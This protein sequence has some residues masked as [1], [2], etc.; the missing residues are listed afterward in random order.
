MGFSILLVRVTGDAIDWRSNYLAGL[1]STNC[2]RVRVREDAT[3]A[4]QCVLKAN[5]EGRQFRVVYDIQGIDSTVAGGIVRKSDGKLLA[6]QF[7]GCPIGCGFSILQQRVSVTSCPQPNR[8]YVN[9][10]GCLNCFQPKL[11]Y[12]HNIM[13]PNFESYSVF[14]TGRLRIPHALGLT[15]R[16]LPRTMRHH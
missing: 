15:R 9:P 11:S 3:K 8:L 16:V 6:L 7:D 13:S 14:S 4:T 1:F 2:G 12:P 10:E 5:S